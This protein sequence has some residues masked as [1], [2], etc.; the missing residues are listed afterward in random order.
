MEEKAE[1]L[2]LGGKLNYLWPGGPGFL[3]AADFAKAAALRAPAPHQL[4]VDLHVGGGGAIDI[5]RGVFAAH[6]NFTVGVANLETNAETHHLGRA[7]DEAGDLN[8]WFSEV[9]L[10]GRLPLRTASFCMERSGHFDAFDQGL[11]MFLPNT[12]FL[13][14]PGHVHAMVASTYRHHGLKTV[15]TRGGHAGGAHKQ[16]VAVRP[17]GFDVRQSRL[18]VQTDAA[19]STGEEA[20]QIATS[21]QMGDDGSVVVRY[22]NREA[23][24]CNLTIEI[25]GQRAIGADGTPRSGDHANEPRAIPEGFARVTQLSANN[26]LAENTPGYPGLVSPQ[27]W[28]VSMAPTGGILTVPAYSYTVIEL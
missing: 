1:E 5:A 10:V 3:N 16:G 14:P 4:I 11:S 7:L 22:V 9:Q 20:W 8:A 17:E 24:P 12:T 6:A 23:T 18:L 2:G 27:S 19:A 25:T 21:A 28:A 15:V 13:Q 26:L